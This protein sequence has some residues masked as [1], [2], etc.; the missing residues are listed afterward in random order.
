MFRWFLA[1]TALAISVVSASAAFVV[2]VT[3]SVGP[4]RANSPDFAQYATNAAYGLYN[5]GAGSPSTNGAPGTASYYAP[6]GTQQGGGAINYLTQPLTNPNVIA[7]GVTNLWQGQVNAPTPPGQTGNWVYFGLSVVT[8]AGETFTP[9]SVNFN[10][11][12]YPAGQASGL[13]SP[14]QGA[15]TLAGAGNLYSAIGGVLTPVTDSTV[16]DNLYYVGIGYSIGNTAPADYS[17]AAQLQNLMFPP[18]TPTGLLTGSYTA[19][20]TTGTAGVEINGVPAPATIALMG[21][22]LA[23]LVTRVRRR[24]A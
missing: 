22:G 19:G 21:L 5:N 4:D 18:A 20:G 14:N 15:T 17:T 8:T 16:V 24:M 23:G 7:A 10:G 6:S 9:S 2:N 13:S 1:T 12:N 3:P 11:I